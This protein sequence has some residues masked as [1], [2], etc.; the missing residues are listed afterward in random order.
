MKNLFFR[1]CEEAIGRRSNLRFKSKIASSLAGL[2]MTALLIIFSGCIRLSAGY[3]HKGAE[4]EEVKSK[5][6]TLDTQD[7]VDPNRPKG[8][9]TT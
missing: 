6:V 9:I 3:W 7:L 2:A 1:H 5:S 8:N 4:D